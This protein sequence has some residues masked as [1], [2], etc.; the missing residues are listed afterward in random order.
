MIVHVLG[1]MTA[2]GNER[3][4]LELIRR[5]PPATKQVL[6]TIDPLPGGALEGL[7]RA[8]PGLAFLHVPYFRRHRTRFV[9]SLA[10]CLRRLRPRGIICYPFGLHLLVGL[11][12]KVSPGCRLIAHVG[13]PP[14]SEGPKRT[15]F[16]NIVLASRC[17]GTALWSCSLTVHEQLSQLVHRMPRDSWGVPNGINVTAL[18]LA[19]RNRDLARASNEPIIA[20]I[21]RLDGIKDHVTL[22]AAFENVVRA[23]PGAK[24]WVV[25][26]GDRRESLERYALEHRLE[27]S[28]RFLGVRRDVGELLGQV[29]LFAF[30]TTPAE[31]F[32]IAMA[33]AMALGLP[34]VAT[35]VPACREVLD[36]GSCGLLVPPGDEKALAAGIL[37]LLD[38]SPRAKLLGNAAAERAR[39]EY[40]IGD[41][42]KKY[43]DYLLYGSF[44]G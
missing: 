6:I 44:G 26:E 21:A 15:L 31:G 20:M 43:F 1:Q 9:L 22:L 29:D 5:A 4:C 16:R 35:D 10:R 32:G 34:I 39:Q 11:A 12:S 42:A 18:L 23:K 36:G 41:C 2:G 19:A 7:F 25:G 37:E 13:N 30:S 27:A 14:P 8:I 38:N 33:E 40:D 28:V 3:L 24:L 17:M